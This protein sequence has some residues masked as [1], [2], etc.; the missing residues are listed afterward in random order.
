MILRAGATLDAWSLHPDEL[1]GYDRA[2]ITVLDGEGEAV[3]SAASYAIP[4]DPGAD[5]ILA[6]VQALMEEPG[7]YTIETRLVAEGRAHYLDP[8]QLVVEAA[9][10]PWLACSIVRDEWEDAPDGDVALYELLELARFQVSEFAR[11]S[12]PPAAKRAAQLAQAKNL[13]N[14]NR[15]SPS[16]TSDDGSFALTPFPIDWAVKAMLRPPAPGKRRVL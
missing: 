8:E 5:L 6:P 11:E 1:E 2:M 3:H 14:A 4:S 15:T 7:V 16:G 13:W 9:R 12:T 10:G